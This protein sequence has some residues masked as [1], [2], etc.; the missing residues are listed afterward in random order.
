LS[1]FASQKTKR[2]EEAKKEEHRQQGEQLSYCENCSRTSEEKRRRTTVFFFSFAKKEDKQ[3]SLLLFFV[4]CLIYR[5]SLP[6]C[7]AKRTRIEAKQV[8]SFL[9][10]LKK[11][12]KKGERLAKKNCCS[13][14]YLPRD[15]LDQLLLFW[16]FL[17][18]SFFCFPSFLAKLKKTR[19]GK[20]KKAR[21]R[22][23][24]DKT[25]Q[26]SCSL[27]PYVSPIVP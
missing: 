27:A 12:R 4:L 20:T 25:Q 8:S 17:L 21:K 22:N 16:S 5:V 18:R 15:S 26:V 11:K 14:P 9:A 23:T 10:K 7:F 2:S 1:F 19:L 13:L 3:V 6:F 24:V